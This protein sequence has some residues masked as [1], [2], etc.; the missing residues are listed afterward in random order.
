MEVVTTLTSGN[1]A[2]LVTQKPFFFLQKIP[3]YAVGNTANIL[4]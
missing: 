2:D 3:F 1:M 4:L